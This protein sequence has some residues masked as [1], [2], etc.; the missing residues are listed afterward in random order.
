MNSRDGTTAFLPL[1]SRIGGQ[2]GNDRPSVGQFLTM[3][4]TRYIYKKVVIGEII[5]T[6]TIEQEMEQ[7]KQLSKIDDTNGETN[8]YQELIV[9]NTEKIE[10][11]MTQMEQWSIISDVLNYVQHSRFHSMK[12][13]ID[14][15]AV[16][17]Y[18][19][20]PNTKEREFRELDFGT[21]PQKLHEGYIDIYEGIQSEIVSA[22]RF[23]E[24]SNLSTTYLGRV[25]KENKDKL[26]AEESFPISE[27]RYTSG[28]H[29]VSTVTG[30]V[31]K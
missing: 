5:N 30:H 31:C 21:T 3:E 9:N 4:Q 29:R 2:C 12:H 1:D 16:N 8:P 28:W 7:E 11:L 6:E 25:D 17:K 15:R 13:T 23:D 20:R 26:G 24:N 22:T 18:K 10:P 27:H 19:H 14:I